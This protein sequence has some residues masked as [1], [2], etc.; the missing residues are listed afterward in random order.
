MIKEN[1]IN[2]YIYLVKINVIRVSLASSD[3]FLFFEIFYCKSIKIRN[4]IFNMNINTRNSHYTSP[5]SITRTEIPPASKLSILNLRYQN[6]LNIKHMKEQTTFITTMVS[7][8]LWL[9]SYALH[10][11]LITVLLFV[12]TLLCTCYYCFHDWQ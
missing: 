11:V 2:S 12:I 8:M 6:G 5:R 9:Y 4:K 3:F 10:N 7:V 1:T